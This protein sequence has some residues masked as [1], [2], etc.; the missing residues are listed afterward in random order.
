[1]KF[2]FLGSLFG[3]L[4]TMLKI[5]APAVIFMILTSLGIG[6]IT[7][8]GIDLLLL[9]FDDKIALLFADIPPTMLSLIAL[10]GFDEAI[11]MMIAAYTVRL[12]ISGVVGGTKS[13][14]TITKS[15]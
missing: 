1:M 9:E 2:S 5:S 12:T 8:T 7:Y 10:A 15:M 3:G 4:W 14:M 11:K 6:F 13:S